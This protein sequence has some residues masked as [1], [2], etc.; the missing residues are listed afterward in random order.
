[1][2]I[3]EEAPSVATMPAK[4]IMLITVTMMLARMIPTT[5]AIVYL[6]NSFMFVLC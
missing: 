6:R 1:L 4:E 2:G 3:E 5:V